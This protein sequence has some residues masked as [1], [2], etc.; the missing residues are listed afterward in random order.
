M[1]KQTLIVTTPQGDQ[2]VDV[3]VPTA[4]VPEDTVTGRSNV[5]DP[6]RE[7]FENES[8][9]TATVR[10][11]ARSSGGIVPTQAPTN[12]LGQEV[13]PH[14]GEVLPDTAV[15]RFLSN[16][17]RNPIAQGAA[18]P[19][20]MGDISSLLLP[21]G[22]PSRALYEMVRPGI[23]FAGRGL[24]AAG[25]HPNLERIAGG[26]LLAT[27]IWRGNPEMV[28]LGAGVTAIP[29]ILTKTGNALLRFAGEDVSKAL[30]SGTRT[31]NVG[32]ISRLSGDIRVGPPGP[33]RGARIAGP[34]ES[35]QPGDVPAV[36]AEPAPYRAATKAA[37]KADEV[38]TAAEAK[39]TANRARLA[40]IERR[41]AGLVSKK[42]TVSESLSATTPEGGRASSS[43]R[44][45]PPKK[46][47]LVP[48][49]PPPI[50]LPGGQVLQRSDNPVIYD[51]IQA[52]RTRNVGRLRETPPQTPPSALPDA[53]GRDVGRVVDPERR[54][55]T[56]TSPTGTE[57]RAANARAL[58]EQEG[59]GIV[60][61]TRDVN[62]AAQVDAAVQQARQ[63]GV[64]TTPPAP[65]ERPLDLSKFITEHA[66]EIE[67]LSTPEGG[68]FNADRL[69]T[70]LRRQ[71]PGSVLHDY[72]AEDV[73]HAIGATR[74]GP[75]G[76][77]PAG[78]VKGKFGLADIE[79]RYG[80][81]LSN[82]KSAPEAYDM[83]HG[84]GKWKTK[85]NVPMQNVMK[86]IFDRRF[87]GW[88]DPETWRD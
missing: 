37:V 88:D 25:E 8:T 70:E 73:T 12:E 47:D 58:A 36:L 27:G 38:A 65:K 74:Q 5:A 77:M 66:D 46:V 45:A 61:P 85:P 42:P 59:E 51:A 3:E 55:L 19:T 23:R 9:R 7:Q 64:R 78:Q 4:S 87:P 67:H 15:R 75:R 52:E 1:P 56:G 31:L 82:I 72:P 26:S 62:G 20:T 81:D 29:P 6:T 28:A 35:I 68:G 48:A 53:P 80:K 30:P 57:R 43:V 16:V 49:G 32:D 69:T 34:A 83:Y 2:E 79:A 40:E 50:T 33:S 44:F 41:K 14:T 13:D 76:L 24:V 11:L 21:S 60:P 84:V 39:V 63:G 86:P 54:T 18:H 71:Y 10:A 17:V 22:L